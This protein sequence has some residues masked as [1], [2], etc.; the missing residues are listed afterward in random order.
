MF[1]TFTDSL[2]RA[3]SEAMIEELGLEMDSQEH[4]ALE[5]KELFSVGGKIVSSKRG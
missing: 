1:G 2:P 3:E 5:K 4:T